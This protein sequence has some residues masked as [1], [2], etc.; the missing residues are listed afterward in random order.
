MCDGCWARACSPS[1][2]FSG[3]P[4]R[5]QATKS[6]APE[7]AVLLSSDDR[8]LAIARD[9]ASIMPPQLKREE[10]GHA[11]FVV[12]RSTGLPDCMSTVLLHEMQVCVVHC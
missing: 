9:V 4:C 8:V 11:A 3:V 7:P 6:S 2:S 10:A 5:G 12:V 1:C